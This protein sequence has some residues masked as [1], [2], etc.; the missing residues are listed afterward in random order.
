MR[1]FLRNQNGNVAVIIALAA[2][3][4][5]GAAGVAADY[6]KWHFQKGRL[7]GVADAAALA[8]SMEYVFEGNKKKSQG[9][10]EAR[11]IAA[12]SDYVNAHHSTLNAAPQ[13][14][15]T[16]DPDRTVTVQLSQDGKRTLSSVLPGADAN[17]VV[18]ATALVTE[19]T[20]APCVIGLDETATPAVR[21][22]G[23]GPMTAH[24]CAVWSNSTQTLSMEGSGSGGATASKFCA[25]GGV[26]PGTMSF[27]TPPEAYCPPVQ[28]PFADVE[29]PAIGACTEIDLKINNPIVALTPGVYCG[30]IKVTSQAVVALAPGEYVI[31]DGS[32]EL[33]GGSSIL[34]VDVTIFL[35]GPGSGLKF[36]GASSINLRAPTDGPYAGIAIYS[37]RNSAPEISNLSGSNSLDI[38]GTLYMPN[39]DLTYS[40]SNSALLPANFTVLIAN[41]LTFTGSSEVTIRSD[42]S[43]SN[44]PVPQTVLQGRIMPRLIK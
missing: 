20:T 42:Y 1:K 38:E 37:D 32:F 22:A 13:V 5:I 12:V 3:P 9:D 8:A 17:I 15:F 24:N 2:I 16:T 36:G 23:S 31:K 34:G 29:M 26:S 19:N 39:Q 40:G 10:A 44:V 41:T 11:A 27:S 18:T 43:A 6:A 21:F 25:V 30:G 7:Q 4:L 33:F 14:S 28:D 35:T